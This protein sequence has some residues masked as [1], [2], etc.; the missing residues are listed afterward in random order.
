MSA[1]KELSGRERRVSQ[2]L[3]EVEEAHRAHADEQAASFVH[4]SHAYHH[5]HLWRSW[6]YAS[7]GII[8]F[9]DQFEILSEPKLRAQSL[10]LWLSQRPEIDEV[11]RL[12]AA[13]MQAHELL[14]RLAH[15]TIV[16]EED[17]ASAKQVEQALN[18]AAAAAQDVFGAA[19]I[20]R[21]ESQ[22]DSDP[23]LGASHRV[24]VSVRVASDAQPATLAEARARFFRLL[25]TKM[26]GELA[27]KVRVV[28]EMAP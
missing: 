24:T 10:T 4:G 21:V 23:D 2:L 9:A 20:L 18:A 14:R 1:V 19:R 26:A 8:N 22:E 17:L 27:A 3:A 15:S 11:R 28:L 12:R 5:H 13:L 16:A 6:V 25:G 7:S